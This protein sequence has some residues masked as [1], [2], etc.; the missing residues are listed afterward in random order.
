[1][2]SLLGTP[3]THPTA[4]EPIAVEQQRSS[5]IALFLSLLLPGVGH[6]YCQKVR[7]GILTM[8]FFCGG[9]CG[10]LLLNTESTAWAIAL[11]VALVMY[12]FAFLDAYY[13]A[14]EI[15]AGLDPYIIGN[16][17]RIAAALNLLTNGLG[18]FYLGER[19][20]GLILFFALRIL[21]AA[22]MNALTHEVSR[23]GMAIFELVYIVIAIDAYRLARKQLKECFPEHVLYDV[24]FMKQGAKGVTPAVP[25]ALAVL[26]AFNYLLLVGVGLSLPDYSKLDRSQQTITANA[27]GKV[28]RNP[29]YGVEMSVP[30]G[31]EFVTDSKGFLVEA[32][33]FDGA[34]SVALIP[35]AK[36]PIGGLPAQAQVLVQ[37]IKE[38]NPG[39][40]LQSEKPT[41]LGNLPAYEVLL[42]AKYNDT[43]VLQRYVLIQRRLT[44]YAFVATAATVVADDCGPEMQRIQQQV[45]V[46]Y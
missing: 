23:V 43:E 46:G 17:P 6:L 38:E 45:R 21:P 3:A 10:A 20:K 7:N 40:H 41:T 30:P 34:C 5:G 14:R 22:F 37:S 31:W 9:V 13:V 24:T 12:V 11:R 32:E 29:A 16:N 2:E 18:Y 36:L 42:A 33:K 26:V 1:M 35:E 15:N 19:K 25:I 28:L 39:F 4:P 44:L 8:L 27:D